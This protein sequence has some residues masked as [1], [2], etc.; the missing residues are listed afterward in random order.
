MAKDYTLEKRKFVV[1]GIALSIVIIYLIR[2]F[3]LQIMTDDYKKHAD[4]NAFLNK[5]QYPS[6]GAIYDRNGKLLV[7][8]QPAY[9]I[10]VI[11]KEIENLDTLDLCESLGI[12]RAQFLKIMNDMRDR[13]RNPGYSK[14]TNQPFMSQLSAEECGVFQEKLFKFRG[15]YVQRR[16]I[17]QY[18]YN[19]AAHALGDI[20]EVSVKDMEADEDGYYIRGDYIGKLGVERTYEKYLRGE[21]GVEVLL[22]DAHGRIQGHY[23]DGEYDKPS[24]PGKNLTLSLDIDLQML[25]ERL[26][27]NKIGSIVAIEPESGEILCLVSSPNYDPHLMIG[28]QRGK[29]HLVLQRDKKKPLLNRA[30]MG[31]YP[32]GSTFKTAQGLTFLQEGIVSTQS[33]LFPCSHGFHYGRLTVGCHAH[34]SPLPLIPSIAT[35]CNSYFCWGLFRM[36]GDRKYGSPQNAITVWKD[37]MVSQGFGYKLGVDLPGEKRGLIP[38]AQFY[39]KAYRGHWNGLTVISIAIGQGEILTTPLQIANLGAT[40]AN[41]GY[42]ITPHIVKEIQGEQLD[43]LYRFPRYTTIDKKHYEDVAIGMRAAVTGGT[44]R[45]AG[46]IL[47]NVE[48][49]GKT[50]TAQNRGHDHSVFMGFA[51]MDKPK[52]AVAV[53]VENGGFGAVYGVPIG[54]LIMEQYLNGTL[55]PSSEAKAEEYSNRIISYGDEER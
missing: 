3:V 49:C 17:R 40:I 54:T 10:T 31:V 15:F 37:H 41:R 48:I 19:A 34:G 50:G 32:P 29:N 9:D 28:R 20:G 42:F 33:P 38:N 44:C 8:N 13:Y 5:I 23:M 27:K 11:P 47:P 26:L 39:D 18:S 46:T 14:Y 36:F 1:G 22:R 12:T 2:L 35:S 52:I 24:I 4:S 16:T 21:K 7:F 51:P 55:S 30:L 45:V 6:R 25:G 43:S 53:Y